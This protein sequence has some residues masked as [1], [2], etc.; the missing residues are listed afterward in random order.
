MTRHSSVT[1]HM[2]AMSHRFYFK[3][4]CFGKYNKTWI[5]KM[6]KDIALKRRYKYSSVNQ[7]KLNTSLR[8]A[9]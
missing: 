7:G 6:K 4:I 8:A 3:I 9:D 2:C 1:T 5:K